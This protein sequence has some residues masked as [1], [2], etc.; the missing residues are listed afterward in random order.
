M[1]TAIYICCMWALTCFSSCTTAPDI[2][3][4]EE[5]SWAIIQSQIFEPNCV[6]CHTAGNSFAKQSGLV[7]TAKE[8]YDNLIDRTPKNEAAKADGLM[9]LETKGLESLYSSFL[10]EKINANDQEH[11]Y[12]DHPDYGSIMP[13]GLPAL[14]NGELEYIRQWIIAGAPL[15][16]MVAEESL[17]EDTSRFEVSYEDFEPLPQPTSGIQLHLGP[18]EVQPNFERELFQYQLL[19]NPE[20]IYLSRIEISMRTGSHHFLLYDF[21]E[22][23]TLPLVNETRDMRDANGTYV[24]PTLKSIENQ[25]FVF[26]TQIKTTDYS[27]PP[28]VALRIPANKGL[29][30]NS[31]YVNYGSEPIIGEVYTNLHTINLSEVEHVAENLFLNNTDI[32][33]PPNQETMLSSSYPAQERMHIFMLWSH[34]HQYMKEYRIFIE[35]G[36]RDGELIYYNN[37]WEHPTLL[38]FDTPIV[39]EPGEAL[40]DEVLYDNTTDKTLHFGLLSTDE[41]NIIFGAYYTD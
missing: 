11:F 29:D 38:N 18:F 14:T 15:E 25:I 8:G 34:A 20:D 16:G 33:L 6:V 5:S 39:L 1:R 40:R 32:N 27:F 7:L 36:E 26:G 23:A 22:G 12:Q 9:L 13:L 17:F 19:D 2:N 31:H 3:E 21:A 35:G 24:Y 41:M 37:D 4:V 30:L 10:W 28:G